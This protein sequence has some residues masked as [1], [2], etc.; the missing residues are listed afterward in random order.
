MTP[1]RRLLTG[2]AAP[3]IPREPVS[4]TLFFAGTAYVT[5]IPAILFYVGSTLVTSWVMKA[6]MPKIDTSA[7]SGLLTNNLDGTAPQQYVYGQVRKGGTISF[8]EATGTNNQYLH[9]CLC[10][11]GHEVDEIGDIYINDEVVTLDGSG[12]VT[13]SPWAS[14]I[15]IKKHT[16]ADSQISDPD[17]VSETS[18]TEEFRGQGIAYI[19]VRLE[20]DQDVFA[21]GIPNITAVVNGKQVYDPRDASTLWSSNAALCVRDYITDVR[22]LSDSSMDDTMLAASANICDEAVALAAG[23]TE[24]RYSL[25]G[26]ISSDNS[27]GSILHDMMT[28]CAGTL[29]WGQ[30]AWKLKVGYYTAPVKTFTLDDLRGSITLQT[31]TSMSDI[32]NAVQGVFND[33]DQDWIAADYPKLTSDTFLAEDNDIETILDLELPM[34]TSSATA[35]RISK[36]SL[37]RGREQMTL[38]A[39]FG[40]SALEVQVGDIVAFTNARYGWTAKEFEVT[41][42]K[43]HTARES[44]AMQ[45]NMTLRE[46]SE[47]AFDW[48]GDETAIISN[49]STLNDPWSV[50]SVGLGITSETRVVYEKLTNV[51]LADVTVS[52]GAAVERIEVQFKLSSATNWTAAGVGSAGVFEIVDVGDAEYDVR[53]RAYNH[54]GV[55]GAWTTYTDFKVSG[56]ADPPED[57]TN[58]HG[59]VY[60][61]TIAL[62]WSPVTDLDLS[63]YRIRHAIE[64]SGATFA[65]ATTAIDKVPRPGSSIVIPARPGTY[66]IR[67]Y[68][69]AGNA[70]QGYTS[71]VIPEDAFEPFTTEMTQT[72]SPTFSGTKTDCAVTSSELRISSGLVA[73]YEMAAVI[74]TGSARRVHSRLD[75]NV[76]RYDPSLGLFDALPGSFD[77]IEGLFDDFTGGTNFSD[78]DVLMFISVSPDSSTWG[79]WQIFKGGDF[80]GR[81]FKFKVELRSTVSGVTPSISG[82]TARVWYN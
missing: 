45:V 70:S 27:P 8:Y 40:L 81:A 10:L 64:E 31:K 14:K 9:M 2:T 80:Y 79:D 33:A 60:G 46:T 54:F 12:F 52:S 13:S 16:G 6:L 5:T 59:Q 35:Q 49:N 78:T 42:W 18:A 1:L 66:M 76:N 11:A 51:I 17:L 58:F 19:Y 7:S 50:A 37:Y 55:R 63:H 4:F 65:N 44:R 56:M 67:A 20:Y 28:A 36:V 43:F 34:T 29:F 22:G 62:E 26:V 57:V 69:K 82:M 73:T 72:D 48:D 47:A 30:G 39:D 68:D 21:N 61:G 75:V 74:D 15:R 53:A 25:N 71:V 77:S 32:F 23:G 24:L 38:S 3:I 41:G